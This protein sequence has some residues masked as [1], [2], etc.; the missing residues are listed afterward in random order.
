M[1]KILL[2]IIGLFL[3]QGLISQSYVPFP[4]D[5]A[6]WNNLFWHQWSANDI[7]LTNSVYLLE[8]DTILNG[9]SYKKVYSYVT[10]NSAS[11]TGYIGG[12][13]EDANKN[14]YFFPHMEFMSTPGPISFPNN[15]SEHLLYTFDNL[16]VGMVLPINTGGFEIEVLDIDSILLGVKYRKRYQIQHDGLLFGPEYWIEGIGSIKD[17][18]SP[19]SHEFE[20]EYYTLCFTDSITY[21]LNSPNGEDVCFYTLSAITQNESNS[22]EF[23]LYPN[24]VSKTLIIKSGT[25]TQSGSVNIYSISGQLM[26]QNSLINSELEIN[27]EGFE[28]GIYIVEITYEESK[29]YLKFIKK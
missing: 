15:T 6:R 16:E 21:Y 2:L 24:P 7:S 10:D 28:S 19:F 3:F 14:I 26:L 17:L 1:K 12:L 9:K 5:T 11:S 8:G 27:I 23:N 29:Q 4:S 20:W 25:A 18:L 13:R 22:L